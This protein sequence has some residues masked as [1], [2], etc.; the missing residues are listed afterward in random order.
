L[1]I[2]ESA[3]KQTGS[4]TKEDAEPQDLNN[5]TTIRL[6]VRKH[7]QRLADDRANESDEGMIGG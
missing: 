3:R 5:P 7:P 6:A 1:G 2:A 4:G